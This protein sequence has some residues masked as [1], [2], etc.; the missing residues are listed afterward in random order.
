MARWKSVRQRA[1]E[2]RK[3]QTT[4]EQILWDRLRNRRLCELKFRRQHPIGAYIVD[5]YC[6]EDRLVIELDGGIHDQQKEQDEQRD[7]QLA[8]YG[9]H[10]LRF[11]NQEVESNLEVVLGKIAAAGGDSA[12]LP[13]CLGEGQP[14]GRPDEE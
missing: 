12:L 13:G 4:A 9:F 1:K 3:I 7:S 2:L 6:D 11:Q 14:G 8:A 5:F 10:I